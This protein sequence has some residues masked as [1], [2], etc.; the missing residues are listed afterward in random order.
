MCS[1]PS[2]VHAV[3][4]HFIHQY[5]RWRDHRQKSSFALTWLLFWRDWKIAMESV[6]ACAC[7]KAGS[8]YSKL[9][10]VQRSTSYDRLILSSYLCYFKFKHFSLT[11]MSRKSKTE[12]YYRFFTVADPRTHEKGHTEYKVTARVSSTII[13]YMIIFTSL[14]HREE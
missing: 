12:E 4:P 3:D 1:Q 7:H 10:T 2:F 9:S 13:Y 5:I 11:V 8:N 6:C 14:Y